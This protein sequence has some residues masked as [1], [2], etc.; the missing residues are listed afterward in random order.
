MN[1]GSRVLDCQIGERDPASMRP[2]FMN[3]GSEKA[4]DVD[5]IVAITLQ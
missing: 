4:T 2:R 3:R 1:R 5:H